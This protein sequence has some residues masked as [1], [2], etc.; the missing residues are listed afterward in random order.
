MS[1]IRYSRSSSKHLLIF[2]LRY[3]RHNK[4]TI[5]CYPQ[6]TDP[7]P[8]G[9]PPD[10][11]GRVFSL[12]LCYVRPS[13]ARI[14][15]VNLFHLC[16]LTMLANRDPHGTTTPCYVRPFTARIVEV[17]RFCLST[18][19]AFAF[20]NPRGATCSCTTRD[21]ML[22]MLSKLLSFALIFPLFHTPSAKQKNWRNHA[23]APIFVYKADCCY[24]TTF[25]PFTI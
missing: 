18:L 21:K 14:V 15:E 8:C 25:L 16:S 22:L 6:S 12:Q 4:Y 20:R 17:V 19:T 1:H 7:L 10:S 24:L 13:T 5:I 9:T 2:S 3:S 23:V 11:G